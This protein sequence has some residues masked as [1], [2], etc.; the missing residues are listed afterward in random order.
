[1]AVAFTLSRFSA[2]KILRIQ[3]YHDYLGDYARN[4]LE[5]LPIAIIKELFSWK[6]AG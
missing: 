2:H 4:R 6:G 5:A 3:R 1:M